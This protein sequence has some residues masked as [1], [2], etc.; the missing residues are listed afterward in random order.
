M[1]HMPSDERGEDWRETA[2]KNL[3][4]AKIKEF[5]QTGRAPRKLSLK[6]IKAMRAEKAAAEPNKGG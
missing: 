5:E 6:D 4:E 1:A 3:A 2:M